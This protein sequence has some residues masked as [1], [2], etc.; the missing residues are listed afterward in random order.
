M[1]KDADRWKVRYDGKDYSFNSQGSAVLAAVK[2]ANSAASLGHEAEVLVQGVDGMAHR[3]AFRVKSYF[4]RSYGNV[5]SPSSSPDITRGLALDTPSLFPPLW[6]FSD[7]P[8][9][10]ASGP[11]F[12]GDLLSSRSTTERLPS[13]GSSS[14]RVLLDMALSPLKIANSA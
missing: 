4:F 13:A 3:M 7:W 2:A 8:L 11:G 9:A 1:S 5:A 10:S 12:A 14:S 6:F